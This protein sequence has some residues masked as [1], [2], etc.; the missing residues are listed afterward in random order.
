[1]IELEYD[2]QVTSFKNL[3]DFFWIYHDP[4]SAKA[5]SRYKQFSVLHLWSYFVRR[6]YRSI[7]F[8]HG[9][10]QKMMAESSLRERERLTGRKIPTVIQP[11]SEFY[12]AEE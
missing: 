11:V 7:I 3:L 10:E 5:C 1:M 12:I 6:Q 9:E 4:H 8:Y 2:P